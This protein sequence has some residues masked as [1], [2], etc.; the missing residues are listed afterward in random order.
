MNRSWNVPESGSGNSS[1]RLLPTISGND[2]VYF[3]KQF[4]FEFK[5]WFQ[6]RFQ[7]R[8]PRMTAQVFQS[9]APRESTLIAVWDHWMYMWSCIQHHY[10]FP[11]PLPRTVSGSVRDLFL[12]FSLSRSRNQPFC[13]QAERRCGCSCFVVDPFF[14]NFSLFLFLFLYLVLFLVLFLFFFSWWWWSCWFLLW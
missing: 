3:Q 5:E 13:E 2:P 11:S 4:E 6:E 9:T 1:M 8:S 7:E 10:D 14:L 12:R